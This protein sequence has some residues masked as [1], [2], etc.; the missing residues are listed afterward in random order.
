MDYK[1]FNKTVADISKLQQIELERITLSSISEL[2]S[3]L[4]RSKV[5]LADAK[6]AGKQSEKWD[7]VSEI[8]KKSQI[9]AQKTKANEEKN[10]ITVKADA[11]KK[12]N[13]AEAIVTEAAKRNNRAIEKSNESFANFKKA[14]STFGTEL[15][16]AWRTAGQLESA[17]KQFQ[18]AAKALGVDVKGSINK[19]NAV[20]QSI[21]DYY[22]A[23]NMN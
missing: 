11:Q 20:I 17:L 12:I 3:I 1:K 23:N 8:D 10:L 19:Y 7:E 14:N 4:K 18:T 5:A 9:L 2:D 16:N 15:Q 21:G 13:V 22:R 6:K